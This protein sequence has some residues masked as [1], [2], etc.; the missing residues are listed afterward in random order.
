MGMLKQPLALGGMEVKN[1]LL[2]S[3]TM[4]SMADLDG[5]VTDALLETYLDL[6]RGGV[7]L[8]ISGACAVAE[9]GRAWPNQ[10]GAWDDDHVAGLAR[11]AAMVHVHGQGCK[12][13]VQ[14]HHKPAG[15]TGYSYGGIVEEK[16]LADLGEDDIARLAGAYGQAAARVKQAGWDAVAVHGGHGYLVSEFFSPATNPRDD[17]WG[18]GIEGRLRFPLAVQGAITEAV[19]PDFPVLW[20]INTSDFLEDGAG[21]EDYA[22]LAGRLAGA[23]VSLIEMSGGIKDQIRLRAKLRRE[24]GEA[25]AYFL[26]ALEAFRAQAPDT[27]LAL[28][29]GLRS[30][31]AMEAA[32]AAGAD[33]LGLSR[34]LISEPDLSHRLLATQDKRPARCTSCN[35]CLLHIAS[36]PL[37]CVEFDPLQ[38]VIK[39]LN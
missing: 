36:Q 13:A 28:T 3:A 4:E 16:S 9:D 27:P 19:G 25:E 22:A 26:P 21:L 10:M 37:K 11:L 39:A 30:P 14:L 6:A 1:R 12:G 8:I 29:G 18:G 7:G 31:A 5:G 15:A 33:M 32:L 2:R 20:K 23:G 38:E 35:K 24:A 17:Q 34:P